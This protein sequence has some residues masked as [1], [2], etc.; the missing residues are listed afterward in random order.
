MES[1]QRKRRR[2]RTRVAFGDALAPSGGNVRVSRTK[3]CL[4]CRSPVIIYVLRM[5]AHTQE[6]RHKVGSGDG[7]RKECRR[8][9]V[10][11]VP[12]TYQRLSPAPD[13]ILLDYLALSLNPRISSSSQTGV[14]RNQQRACQHSIWAPA[15]E[16]LIIRSERAPAIFP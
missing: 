1:L 8:G 13:R 9:G 12:L 6:K 15:R 4:A 10:I 2:K 7:D 5:H 3:E 14:N 11:L 16:F